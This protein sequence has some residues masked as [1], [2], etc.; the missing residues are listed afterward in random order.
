V[1]RTEGS[2]LYANIWK[3]DDVSL[4]PIV[5]S[6]HE[7]KRA[8]SV[9]YSPYG[10]GVEKAGR[11]QPQEGETVNTPLILST[12]GIALFNGVKTV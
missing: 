7:H 2:V 8:I 3:Y 10:F 6:H 9:R 5:R 11:S 12:L 1:H 4:F